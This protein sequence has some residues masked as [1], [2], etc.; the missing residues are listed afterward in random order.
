MPLHVL[1]SG[2]TA[3]YQIVTS[4]YTYGADILGGDVKNKQE[5]WCRVMIRAREKKTEKGRRVRNG[6]V[7]FQ[8]QEVSWE[9]KL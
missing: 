2:N 1:F 9:G 3:G 7:Q 8:S 4:P 5:L 6:I